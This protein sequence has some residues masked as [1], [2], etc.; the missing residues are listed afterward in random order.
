MQDFF[1][2]L[3]PSEVDKSW[4]VFLNVAGK[5]SIPA[6]THYPA[7]EHP[8]GY[9]FTWKRGRILEEYQLIYLT[10]GTGIFENKDGQTNIKAGDILLIKPNE[11]H[12]YRPNLATGWVENYIGFNGHLVPHFYKEMAF[13]KELVV[14]QHGISARMLGLFEA[15]FKL[16][17]AEQ[18]SFQQIATGLI[19]QIFG[20]MAA[21]QKRGDFPNKA[22]E[23]TIQKIL[24][25]IRTEVAAPIDLQALAKRHHISYAS[26]RKL[27]KKYTGKSPRQYHLELKVLRAKELI[28]SSDKTMQEISQLLH[29]ESIHY[30]SR[31]FKKKT[32]MSPTALRKTIQ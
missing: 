13:L 22:M 6:N 23:Q 27:F 18:P 24:L 4:G 9:Y 19:V 29:F 11:F 31:F 10:K 30:F 1:K 15:V 12:R 25:E 5:A 32:G 17:Q 3:T 28:I 2:Y 20:N 16:V 8:T 7:K 14:F 21:Q 26:F